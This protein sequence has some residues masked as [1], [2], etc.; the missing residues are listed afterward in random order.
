[1]NKNSTNAAKAA[2]LALCSA[3]VSAIALPAS[4]QTDVYKSVNVENGFTANLNGP[5]R[6]NVD[7]YNSPFIVVDVNGKVTVE[8]CTSPD[9][10]QPVGNIYSLRDISKIT[11]AT[12]NPSTGVDYTTSQ[13]GFLGGVLD[14]INTNA[15]SSNPNQVEASALNTLAITGE[16]PYT[17]TPNNFTGAQ[18]VSFDNDLT[19]YRNIAAANPDYNVFGAAPANNDG[20]ILAFTMPTAVPEAAT[21]TMMLVGVAGIGGAMRRNRTVTRRPQALAT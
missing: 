5:G 8:V 12:L 20:Q 13:I 15:A 4:A 10:D 11:T 7:F 19:N 3:T 17:V 18:L 9:A 21:W 2:A 6:N 16:G 14:L 1:M